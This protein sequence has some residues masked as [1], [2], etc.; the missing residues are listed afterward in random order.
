M[1]EN[2]TII[3]GKSLM[4]KERLQETAAPHDRWQLRVV[5]GT[6]GFLSIAFLLVVLL[7]TWNW[8]K[9]HIEE[10]SDK[11]AML[12]VEFDAAIREYISKYVRPEM[13]KRVKNQDEF[14]PEAMAAT[15]ADVSRYMV[16]AVILCIAFLAAIAAVILVDAKRRRRAEQILRQSERRFRDLVEKSTDA[17]LMLVDGVF[18]ECNAAAAAMFRGTRQQIIGLTPDAVSPEFQPDGIRS[19]ESAAVRIH[20]AIEKGSTQFEWMHY[21]LD[22][23]GFWVDVTLT[24]LASDSGTVLFASCRDITSRK[25]AENEL[26]RQRL[27]LETILDAIGAPVYYKNRQGVYI[28]CN[29]AFAEHIGLPREN[30]I[31]KTIFGIAPQELAERY[32][33]AD[34]ELF[35]NQ[36]PQVYEGPVAHADGTCCEMIIRKAPFYDA[37]GE[38]LGIVGTMLDITERKRAESALA[39]ERGRLEHIL[40]ITRTGIDIIDAEYNLCYVNSGWQKIYGDYTG[41]KCYAYFKG[42]TEPCSTCGIPQALETKQII[43]TEQTLPKED[44]R[45][46]E[47][48]TI[49]FQNSSGQWLAAEFKIDITERKRIEEKIRESESLQRLLLDNISAGIIIVDAGTHVI[50]HANPMAAKLFGAPIDQI[51][52]RVCHRF[53]CPAEKNCCPITDLGREVD[54]A[55][56]VM[57]CADGGPTPILKSVK[58]IQIGGREKLLETFVDITDRKRAEEQL[59]KTLAEAEKLNTYLAEQTAYANHMTAKAEM[60]SIA[61][62]EFLANMS[63]EIRTP[64]N[65]VIGM[66]GLLLDTELTDEQRQYA[67]IVQRSG[68]SLL[69]LINDILDFSKIEAGK[70]ELETLDFDIRDVLEDFSGMLAVRAHEKGL[71]FICAANPDIPSYLQGDPG[72][73]RQILTNLAG[74]AIK[75]TENGEVAIG[76]EMASKT[77]KNVV[78]RFSIRDTGIGIPADKIDQLFEKFTQVDTSTTRK[79]GGTGLGLAISRQLVEKMNGQIGIHSELGKGSEFWFTAC[80]A[81]QPEQDAKRKTHVEICGKRILVVDDNQT[82]RDILAT[83]LTSWGAVVS[84]VSSGALA[85]EAIVQAKEAQTPFDVVITDMQMPEMDGIMLGRAIRQDER[86]KETRLMMMTSLG[87]H[88]GSDELAEIGFA[89]WMTKPVRPSELF[90]HLTEAMTGVSSESPH[91]A[92]EHSEHRPVQRGAIRILLAEDNITN[93][94]V[95][96]GMLKKLGLHADA[97]ANGFEAVKAMEA[98][99][100]DLILMDVQM[101]EL[102]GLEATKRIRASE[103]IQNPNVP[104]IAMTAHAMQGDR[105]KCLNVGMNDYIPKP[106]AFKSLAEKLDQ[107]LPKKQDENPQQK[108]PVM[109]ESSEATSVLQTPVFD[110]AGFLDRLMGDEEIA[111]KIVEVFLD[112]IPKQI[113]SLKQALAVCDPETAQRVAHSIK[114]AAANVGGEAL[115]ELAAQVEKACKE[116]NLGSVSDSCPQLESQFNRLKEAMKGKTA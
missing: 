18:C 76:V 55:D 41:Q 100:Y 79:Y 71:E 68:E 88:G 8:T 112:D 103:S 9:N 101:P 16:G 11:Q 44:N 52:G 87:R 22:G 57:L 10:T 30:I 24:A 75:F 35:E 51:T 108:E 94:Q 92:S 109:N 82:N 47:V 93:Q 107:W 21:R 5:L 67:Q 98:I 4:K 3:D 45:I 106:V 31:G 6:L 91:P 29:T 86:I 69:T 63:H 66:T 46:V 2:Q 60:A 59:Q 27:L 85:L 113:E 38:I 12:A 25:Q 14:I 72:R 114:G 61:K 97:V 48:H 40:S 111:E 104:I 110:R 77:D 23:T 116:S 81:L 89:A 53:L 15:R 99:S 49:P 115:R 42:L 34:S 33:R 84:N 83:R 43:V 78:L 7:Q 64:M 17:Y 36:I 74:N 32:S 20:T 37:K 26:S 96:L 54:N 95:A 105:E 58:C 80:L 65:G 62:S 56:R 39:E 50:E 1:D 102:D 73:L 90:T 19:T 28:G 13:E 70:L